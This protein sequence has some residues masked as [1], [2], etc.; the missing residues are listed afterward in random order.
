MRIKLKIILLLLSQYFCQSIYSQL[1]FPKDTDDRK[2]VST[3]FEGIW[4]EKDSTCQWI[5]NLSESLQFGSEPKDT[6]STKIDTVFNYKGDRFKK[7]ILTSTYVRNSDCHA[8]QPSLG[9]IE[10][11]LNEETNTYE[12]SQICKFIT[13]YGTWGEAPKKRGLLQL[14][15]DI[16]CVKITEYSNGMG[17]EYGLTSL[18]KDGKKIFS[19]SSFGTNYDAVE[20][21]Y[22]KYKYSSTILFDK[23]SNT[24]EITKKGK[25]PNNSG[26]IVKVNSISTYEYDGEF[27]TKKSTKNIL[28]K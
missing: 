5:P 4:R 24:I 27:L 21:D 2:I 11:D 23:K 13:K 20:F 8:C 3:L 26:K 18:F 10:L 7:I 17:S 25:E 1:S 9:I 16:Y 12:I 6:L 14:G 22:Q 19:F 28:A 15:E